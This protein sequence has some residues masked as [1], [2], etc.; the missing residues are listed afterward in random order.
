MARGL[1]ANGLLKGAA[2]TESEFATAADPAIA[3]ALADIKTAWATDEKERAQGLLETFREKYPE[4]GEERLR[5]MLPS[6][7]LGKE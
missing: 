5:A 4:V 3:D 1:F 7:L 6:A 2:E